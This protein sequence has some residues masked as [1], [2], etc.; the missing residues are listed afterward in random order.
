M[1]VRKIIDQAAEERLLSLVPLPHGTR[2][3][4][5]RR[6]IEL[7]DDR[8]ALYRQIAKNASQTP[9]PIKIRAQ[10]RALKA[11]HQKL[12]QTLAT[13]S[14]DAY[15][16][17]ARKAGTHA[18]DPASSP[19]NEETFGPARLRGL[20]RYSLAL[21]AFEDFGDWIERALETYQEIPT[22]RPADHDLHWLVAQIG[23]LYRRWTRHSFTRTNK[24]KVRP[25][26]FVKA[27]LE[28]GVPERRWTDG[29]VDQSMRAGIKL[30]RSWS[31]WNPSMAKTHN[32]YY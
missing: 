11:A 1:S 16:L 25:R 20:H 24:G 5:S 12:S 21:E 29:E 30:L 31:K 8:V 15:H 32:D 19:L 17:L 3:V 27:V 23:T 6:L 2:N 7:V 4:Q 18:Y 22:G 10:L 13:I 14:A 26:D 28:I 9:P